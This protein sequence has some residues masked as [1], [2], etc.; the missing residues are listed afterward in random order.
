MSAHVLIFT[1]EIHINE[2]RS[3]KEKRAVMNPILEGARNR[4]RVASAETDY[5]DQWNH[6]EISFVAVSATPGHATGIIDNVERFVWSFPEADVIA[7]A[8]S[9]ADLS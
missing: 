8:R 3:L 5:F 2:S 4:Y 7:S 6:A 1:A 9:W